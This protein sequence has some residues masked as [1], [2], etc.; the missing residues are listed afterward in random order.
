[1]L[2][3]RAGYDAARQGQVRA[4]AA[5]LAPCVFPP[6]PHVRL[7]TGM[8]RLRTVHVVSQMMPLLMMRHRRVPRAMWRDRTTNLGKHWIEQVRVRF[9]VS[10]YAVPL[11]RTAAIWPIW[12]SQPILPNIFGLPSR[13][14]CLPAPSSLLYPSSPAHMH[15]HAPICTHRTPQGCSRTG[16]CGA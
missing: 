10:A 5:R 14:P 4:R 15:A 3:A 13:R 12:L 9:N 7:L 16:T 6:L 8:R 11:L 2:Q 1:M